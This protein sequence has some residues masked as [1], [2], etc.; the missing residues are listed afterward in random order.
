MSEASQITR[1][2]RSNLAFALRV[3]PAERRGDAVVFYAFCRTLDDLAD[4]P[5]L[6]VETR[7]ALLNNWKQ[8]LQVGFA[9]PDALQGE[10]LA[11]MKRQQIPVELLLAI[12]DGCLM[13]LEPQRYLDWEALDGYIWKVACAVGLVSIRIF[14]CQHPD[15]EAYA[16]ALG[17]ALQLTNILRDVGEDWANQQRIY[18]PMEV[19]EQF[20]CNEE[21]LRRR[22]RDHGFLPMMHHVAE[23]AERAYLEA[24]RGLS[25]VDHRALAPARIMAGVYQQLLHEMKADNFRVF[26]KRYRVSSY[27][28]FRIMAGC[29]LERV[30]RP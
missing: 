7:R 26:E 9:D 11:M 21:T 1:R 15:S 28:K 4:E 20:G 24:K 25:A 5:G 2:A 3:L 14:G 16:V 30:K 17:R 23:R 27:R 6:P 22:G 12:V 19:M 13:D 10:L 18:L 29:L 8:G